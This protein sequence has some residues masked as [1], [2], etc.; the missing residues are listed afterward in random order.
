MVYHNSRLRLTPSLGMRAATGAMDS[1]TET[2]GGTTG[3]AITLDVDRDNDQSLLAEVSLLA[4]ADITRQ[5]VVSGLLGASAGCR[6]NTH[7]L[8]GHFATGQRPLRANADGLSDDSLFI[9]AGATYHINA[10][11]RVNLGYRSEFRSG[12]NNLNGINLSSTIRF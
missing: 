1:F 9:G 10:A 12:S 3:S 2:S 4:E 7:E 5:L 8:S 6:D 11:C